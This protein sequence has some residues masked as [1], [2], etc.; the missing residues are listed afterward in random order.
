[1]EVVRFIMDKTI[2]M[3]MLELNNEKK[4]LSQMILSHK[5]TDSDGRIDKL[6]YL[7]EKY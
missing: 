3:R 7:M 6:R 2:E 4:N 5:E 1:M